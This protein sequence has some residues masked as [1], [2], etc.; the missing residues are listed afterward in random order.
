[1]TA[2]KEHGQDAEDKAADDAAEVYGQAHRH[3]QAVVSGGGGD[4]L[5]GPGAG[6]VVGG[7]HEAVAGPEQDGLDG[8][9]PGQQ[10]FDPA[11]GL[12]VLRQFGKFGQRG[13]P[14]LDQDGVDFGKGVAGALTEQVIQRLRAGTATPPRASGR[15]RRHRRRT[16]TASRTA[17]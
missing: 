3:T 11:L 5:G 2:A 1:M 17:E 10:V 6:E 14:H 7:D 13:A 8:P 12:L 16:P 15:W 4:E 9:P